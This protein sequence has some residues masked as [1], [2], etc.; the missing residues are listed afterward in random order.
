MAGKEL[1]TRLADA[2]EDAIGR[3]SKSP[4][5]DQALGALQG[6]RERVDEMQKRMLGIDAL[7]TRVVELEQRV[8]VI[9]GKPSRRAAAK[10]AAP[11]RTRRP[12][13]AAKPATAADEAQPAEGAA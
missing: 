12:S 1:L 6:L 11:K 3:L 2:G 9:E 10:P 5:A 7:E 13:S 4:G 8:A